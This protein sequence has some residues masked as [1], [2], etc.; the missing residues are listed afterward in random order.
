MRTLAIDI[1]GTKIALAIVEEGTIIQR[2]QMATP[3]V[4]DVTKFVQAILEKVT[5]WL[6]SIDYVGVSTTG[7]VTPEGITSINPETL[8]FPVPFPLAQTLEQL[9]NKPVSILNDAQAAAWFEFVQLKNP[10]LNMAFITV[11]TGVGGGII[12]DGKLH[13]GNCG[14]AGHIGHMSVAIEGPLCGCGQRG[15]VESM[16]SGNAIQRESEAIF[17]GAMSNVE[18]FK[19]AAFNPK[20]EAIINRSVQAV[21]TLCCNLKACLD[22]DII[23]LGGGI[24]LA[25]GYLER[26]NKAIQ[27]RPSVFHVPVTSAYGDYDACLLGAAFQ[28]KE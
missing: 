12:I 3:V 5:E 25:E 18:L 7:Y 23:V 10:R 11:S 27:S 21:A 4:Q 17:T 28:F 16:A 9:T 2:Y 19:Q 24:G 14:L 13:K 15:C 20:A 8:K 6:P 26:L 22:L 1:G